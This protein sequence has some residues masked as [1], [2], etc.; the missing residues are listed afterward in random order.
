[1]TPDELSAIFGVG[2]SLL[3]SYVPG[4][5]GWYDTLDAIGK[6]LVM[7]AG[8]F[9]IAAGMFGLACFGEYAGLT[10]DKPGAIVAVRA[11]IAAAVAN[12]ATYLLSP[13]SK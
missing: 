13:K 10:C 1:M 2:L 9:I 12:Q 11:F 8:L 7:L 6:R 4:A 5:A 3:F